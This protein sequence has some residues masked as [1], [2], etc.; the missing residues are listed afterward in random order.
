MKYKTI[1]Q[2]K[3]LADRKLQ[4]FYRKNLRERCDLCGGEY[5]CM[6]HFIPKSLSNFLR[7]DIHNLIPVCI[8]CHSKFHS[9]NEPEMNIL[10]YK[11]KGEAWFNWIQ[12]SRRIKKR[13][14]RKE[15]E[16]LIKKYQ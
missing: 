15:L 12:L 8:K 10:I 9:F 4:D 13:D 3:K 16:G 7:Y 1:G 2:L 11:L 6:H 14:N 5:F